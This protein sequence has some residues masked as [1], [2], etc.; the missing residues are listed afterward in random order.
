MQQESSF[1]FL[2]LFFIRAFLSDVSFPSHPILT[3]RPSSFVGSFPVRTSLLGSF[4]PAYD[5]P[6][7]AA[8]SRRWNLSVERPFADLLAT[9]LHRIAICGNEKSLP[10][11]Y[12]NQLTSCRKANIA[13]NQRAY[14]QAP[15]LK[16]PL[17]VPRSQQYS[18]DPEQPNKAH[19]KFNIKSHK[20]RSGQHT[21]NQLPASHSCADARCF[22]NHFR[23]IDHTNAFLVLATSYWS[24]YPCIIHAV[25][26][27]MFPTGLDTVPVEHDLDQ[28]CT[29]T[30][31]GSVT[32]VIF[33]SVY[34]TLRP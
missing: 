2:N 4:P 17:L 24:T 1:P 9:Q 11:R 26:K 10:A 34:T 6:A 7:A 18:V 21:A 28:G 23:I 19:A 12:M 31:V 14:E 25:E 3:N 32:R 15:K 29:Y 20:L 30:A 22:F 16:P 8:H 33:Y 5:H 13:T 27:H